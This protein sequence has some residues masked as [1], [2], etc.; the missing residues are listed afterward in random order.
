LALATRCRSAR[1]CARLKGKNAAFPC[2]AHRRAPL[3]WIALTLGWAAIFVTQGVAAQDATPTAGVPPPELCQ[4]TPPNFEELRAI[5]ADPLA[6]PS[7]VWTPGTMPEGR[8]ADPETIAGI[9][10][11]LRELVACF[12][13]DEVLRAYGLYTDDY[14][15]RIFSTQDPL[16][17]GVYDAL[18]TPDPVDPDERSAILAI[19]DVRVFDDGTVGANVTIRYALIPVPKRFFFTFVRDGERWLIDGALGEISFSVP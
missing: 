9:T 7:A 3:R 14:L 18:A 13:A 5:L 2:R 12:N 10:A 19:E 11:T 1:R 15:Q 8:P 17:Q 16:T 6:S 4:A